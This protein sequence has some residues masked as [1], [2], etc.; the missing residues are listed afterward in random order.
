MTAASAVLPVAQS[1]GTDCV[2][3][4]G[5][6]ELFYRVQLETAHSFTGRTG[7]VAARLRFQSLFFSFLKLDDAKGEFMEACFLHGINKEGDCTSL[8]H[9]MDLPPHNSEI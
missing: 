9:N 6:E 4:S 7:L 5:N 3:S 8:S 1:T 2:S